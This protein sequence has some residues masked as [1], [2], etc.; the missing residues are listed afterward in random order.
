MLV[1]DDLGSGDV[2]GR[3]PESWGRLLN[4]GHISKMPGQHEATG[5][6]HVMGGE[7]GC[8]HLGR[9]LTRLGAHRG[10]TQL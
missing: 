8:I 9:L 10:S 7:E 4:T 5:R 1:T 3:M 6:P 2:G